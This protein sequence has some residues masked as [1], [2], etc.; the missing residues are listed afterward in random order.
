M[1]TERAT[2]VSAPEH[3][4]GISGHRY[5]TREASLNPESGASHHSELQHVYHGRRSLLKKVL[6][7]TKREKCILAAHLHFISNVHKR[8]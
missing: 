4:I 2:Y 8:H 6:A 7:V 3:Y 1:Q 5:S